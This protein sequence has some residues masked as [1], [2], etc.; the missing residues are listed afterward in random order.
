MQK[1][2]PV[3]SR[4][5]PA[6][7]RQAKKP[8]SDEE[9]IA[10]S[11][12]GLNSP[13]SEKMGDSDM[14]DFFEES[15]D[16]KRI[17]LA[18]SYI[19]QVKTSVNKRDHQDSSTSDS[20]GSDLGSSSD[21]DLVDSK[22]RRDL[23]LKRQQV[24]HFISDSISVTSTTFTR[25]HKSSPTCV[26][27]AV[28]GASILTGGKDGDVLLWDT[29]TQKKTVFSQKT[30]AISSIFAVEFASPSVIAAA[31]EDKSIRLWDVR[32]PGSFKTLRGHQ[33]RVTGLRYIPDGDNPGRLY[34]CGAD[35]G[36]K[37]WLVEGMSGK[38]LESYFGHTGEVLSLD[39][40]ELDK[41]VT[42]GADHTSR[43]WNLANDS[44]QVFSSVHTAPID[45]VA[46][47]DSKHFI[48]G[49]QDGCVCVWGSSYKKAMAVTP[50]AH[51]VGSW[52]SA[53]AAVKNTDLAASGSAE[54][55]IRMWKIAKPEDG[56][57][58]QKISMESLDEHNIAIEG[59]INGLDFS[60]SGRVMAAAVGRDQRLGR[61]VSTPQAKN[62][63]LIA[64]LSHEVSEL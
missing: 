9:S 38:Y 7:R 31:G 62:G 47:L 51:G 33:G 42:G 15:V 26:R 46:S 55:L 39:I 43:F 28:D 44:H 6:K 45:C 58:K 60:R 36:L 59:V 18:K 1:R 2:R 57:K 3:Q 21:E 54:G 30:P 41:P 40:S 49:G 22:L 11:D 8:E 64:S 63:L 37:V 29:E 19:Q 61:W 52:V 20:E 13:T 23:K 17:R 48:S 4:P 25:G 34:S 27:V 35:K 56:K 32:T 16:E 14:D 53:V 24:K 5:Q 10:S 50:D 12:E